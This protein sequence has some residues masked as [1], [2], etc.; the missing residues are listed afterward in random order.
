M[1]YILLIQLIVLCFSVF[2]NKTY[3]TS[4]NKQE[5]LTYWEQLQQ[6]N[7]ELK[8]F[9]KVD[10]NTYAISFNNIPFEGDIELINIDIQEVTYETPVPINYIATIEIKFPEELEQLKDGYSHSFYRWADSSHFY[11]DYNANNWLTSKEYNKLSNSVYQN[12]EPSKLT[13]LINQ[14]SGEVTIGL[15]LLFLIVM[16]TLLLFLWQIKQNLALKSHL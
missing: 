4:P 9:N 14:Y 5:L 10:T 11:Y 6:G 1:K 8:S 12:L 2:I 13:T 16:S 3:A 15:T 7:A